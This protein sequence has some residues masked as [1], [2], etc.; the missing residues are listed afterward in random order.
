M[1]SI[2]SKSHFI[3]GRDT[4]RGDI[5]TDIAVI[6][7]GMAGVLTA[8]MLQKAGRHAVILEADRICGGQTRNTTGKITSQ[9]RMIYKRLI[10]TMGEKAAKQYAFANQNAVEEYKKLIADERIDCDFEE[11]NAFLYGQD[12]DQ[13]AEEAVCAQKL[14]LPASFVPELPAP[15][16]TCGVKFEGQGQFNPVKFIDHISKDLTIYENTRVTSAEGDILI[17]DR[18]RVKAKQAVFACHFPFIN[19]PGMYF[20]KMHQ[21][22]SYILALENTGTV[23]GMF[24]GAEEH[25]YSVRSYKN[26]ILFGGEGHRSGE[27]AEGDRYEKLR[28]KAQEWFPSCREVAR[29]S[30]QD[31]MTGDSVPYIGKYCGSRPDWYVAT[32]FQ[33][34]GMTSSMVSALLLR[35]L[36]CGRENQYAEVFDPSR[37]SSET[38]SESIK[39]G[40]HAVKGIAKAVLGGAEKKIDDIPE[41]QGG[42]IVS[43]GEKIGIYKD[44]DRKI[45][46]VDVK[47]PHLGCQLEWNADELSWDCPCHGSRFD[48]F[49]KLI[50]GPATEG[51]ARE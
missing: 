34:W 2:W 18:G 47:C 36:I 43:D 10:D 19:F 21:E 38:V 12:P 39:D 31:C 29:W 33:K 27:N 17:T 45:Y 13:L 4:L 3:K 28:K 1:E 24:I 44:K 7:A 51:I 22:R 50:S 26:L 9:H 23:D 41:G 5:E 20:A 30:A 48:R 49:G 25:S 40:G 32:G 14:G 6:G 37:M 15:F 16:G 42:I 11:K 35:D 46:T 8:Y